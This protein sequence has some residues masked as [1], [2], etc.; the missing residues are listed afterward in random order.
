M[1]RKYI[2]RRHMTR[3][4]RQTEAI[5]VMQRNA[6]IYVTLREWPWWKVY[7]KLKPLNVAYRIETQIKERDQKIQDLTRK[8]EEQ[9]QVAEQQTQRNHELASQQTEYEDLVKHQEAMVRELEE[10]KRVC[11]EKLA[12]AED[13]SQ[14]LE[15]E[16]GAQA[17][18]IARLHKEIR[19]CSDDNEKLATQVESLQQT[20]E[21]L[22]ARV[23][24]LETNNRRLTAEVEENKAS[25]DK[26]EQELATRAT[27]MQEDVDAKDQRIKELEQ[28][29]E[30]LK[31][32]HDKT[33]HGHA[34]A[35]ASSEQR[36]Q[37]IQQRVEASEME[38]QGLVSERDGLERQVAESKETLARESE[39]QQALEGRYQE[40]LQQWNELLEAEAAEAKAKAER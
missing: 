9:T 5:K 27:V 38:K 2:A 34:A 8:L 25:K 6:R 21:T 13:V 22:A 20:N 4:A 12:S 39:A 14:A 3:F 16:N 17:S 26:L 23:E 36:M 18:M 37:E 31:A 35:L 40:L 33:I 32:E 11:L 28:A 30:V 29:L 19:E 15:Q 10:G 7:A 1:C 24:Y